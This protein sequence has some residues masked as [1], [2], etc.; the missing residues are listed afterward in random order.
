MHSHHRNIAHDHGFRQC[1]DAH[2]ECARALPDALRAYGL[3]H[4]CVVSTH[5]RVFFVRAA[6]GE[7]FFIGTAADCLDWLRALKCA[8]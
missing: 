5:P 4:E 6:S 1:V 7:I 2:A 8:A 3:A